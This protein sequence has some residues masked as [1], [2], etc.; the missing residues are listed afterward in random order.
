MIHY[1][2]EIYAKSSLFVRQCLHQHVRVC[3][4]VCVDRI[5]IHLNHFNHFN[6][7]DSIMHNTVQVPDLAQT[8]GSSDPS[9]LQL[10]KS[11]PRN[12]DGL[13]LHIL[14]IFTDNQPPTDKLIAA[15]KALY[16]SR[17]RSTTTPPPDA[18]FLVPILSGL[19]KEQTIEL[20]PKLVILP[21]KNVKLAFQK[22]VL[23]CW[24]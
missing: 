5:P 16:A 14:H 9:I 10:I 12:G 15:V 22:W 23:C 6:Q 17:A 3:V 7:F 19:K 11:F 13:A 20:L 2:G 21:V 4:C 1:L 18:R 24:H 8:L